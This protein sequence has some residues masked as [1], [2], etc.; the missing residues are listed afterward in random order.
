MDSGRDPNRGRIEANC[1]PG[2]TIRRQEGARSVSDR[3]GG[4][5]IGS[6]GITVVHRASSSL[7]PPGESGKVKFSQCMCF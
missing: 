3:A 7:E 2:V 5:Q 6:K 1:A 4:L